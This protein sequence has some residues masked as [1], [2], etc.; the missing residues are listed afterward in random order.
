VIFCGALSIEDTTDIP[1]THVQKI[2][3][4][5]TRLLLLQDG[6][7]C[8]QEREFNARNGG[9]A[10]EPV[11]Y[12]RTEV[13]IGGFVRGGRGDGEAGDELL[14][15]AGDVGAGCIGIGR[16]SDGTDQCELDNVAAQRGVVAVAEQGE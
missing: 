9:Q 4:W 2:R 12:L 16:E 10:E 8:W 13:R 11:F 6:E 7:K 5:G 15:N 14:R 3:T 1:R